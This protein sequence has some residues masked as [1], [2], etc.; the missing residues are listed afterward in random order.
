[1]LQEIMQSPY[2]LN[3]I[4]ITKGSNRQ[5]IEELLLLQRLMIKQKLSP[6]EGQ[7][8][9]VLR[10]RHKDSYLYL[11]KELYPLQYQ[12]FLEEQEQLQQRQENS[13]KESLLQRQLVEAERKEYEQWLAFQKRA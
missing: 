13:V 11:L 1:M 8:Y 12:V 2:I 6:A 7:H 3:Q 10:N 5:F 9:F 4:K